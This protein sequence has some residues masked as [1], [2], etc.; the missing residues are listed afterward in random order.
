VSLFD[1]IEADI[2]PYLVFDDSQIL[3]KKEKTLHFDPRT[4]FPD[5]AQRAQ[6]VFSSPAQQGG[7]F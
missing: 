1:F 4:N 5:Q 3:L 6:V 7:G 2:S